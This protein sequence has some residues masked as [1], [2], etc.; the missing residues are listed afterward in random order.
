[1][2]ILRLARIVLDVVSFTILIGGIIVLSYQEFFDRTPPQERLSG[3]IFSATDPTREPRVGESFQVEWKTT[4]HIRDCPGEV[5]NELKQ[6]SST[7]PFLT[8]S[9][10]NP[11]M[12]STSFLPPPWLLASSVPGPAVYHVT[13]WWYCSPLSKFLLHYFDLHFHPII[14]TG[15]DIPFTILPIPKAESQP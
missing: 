1:V 5:E 4:P 6:G 15:P 13:T 7:W 10:F 3:V 8:R 2:T 11:P 9:A 14:Q 12:G